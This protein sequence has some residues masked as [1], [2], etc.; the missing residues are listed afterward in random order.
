[1]HSAAF[2]QYVR[3][4]LFFSSLK[5]K[6]FCTTN[7]RAWGYRSTVRFNKTL[8]SCDCKSNSR[9]EDKNCIKDVTFILSILVLHAETSVPTLFFSVASTPRKVIKHMTSDFDVFDNDLDM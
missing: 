1:M 9:Y 7:L 8:L 5:K 2:K 6:R 3:H 4:T